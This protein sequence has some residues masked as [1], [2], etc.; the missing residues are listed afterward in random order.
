MRILVS[1]DE[2]IQRELIKFCL[3]NELHIT[4]SNI[5][6]CHDGEQAW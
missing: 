6:F 4:E 5:V 3:V 2:A 1:E